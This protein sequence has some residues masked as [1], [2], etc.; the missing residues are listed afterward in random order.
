MPE[1]ARTPILYLPLDTTR[2]PL[3]DDDSREAMPRSCPLYKFPQRS[4]HS[5]ENARA[6]QDSIIW[7]LMPSLSQLSQSNIR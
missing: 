7:K 1:N 5:K 4:V 2:E 6:G 3:F